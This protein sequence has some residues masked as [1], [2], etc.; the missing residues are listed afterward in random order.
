MKE[1][2][3]EELHDKRI[4]HTKFANVCDILVSRGYKVTN[5]KEYNEK[6][7]FELNGSS[8]EFSKYW[9]ASATRYADYLIS[10]YNQELQLAK[11]IGGQ[12]K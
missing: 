8:F 11:L 4:G 5:I 12:S 10:T 3:I 7:K 2:T 1:R 9:K 6:F